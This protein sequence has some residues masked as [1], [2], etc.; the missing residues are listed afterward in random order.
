MDLVTNLK[1]LL[2][3]LETK[4]RELQ[5]TKWLKKQ[6]ALSYTHPIPR[7]AFIA[8]EPETWDK[9]EPVFE[10]FSKREDCEL[11]LYVCPSY[12]S[13]LNVPE[14]YG[15]EW[16]YFFRKYPSF[17]KSIYKEDGSLIDL[18]SEEL[19]YIFYGDPYMGHFPHLYR[20][21][22][23]VQSNAK[24]CYIPYG[25]YGAKFGYDLMANNTDFFKNMYFTF[26][27]CNDVAEIL[28]GLLKDVSHP[29]YRHIMQLGY[30]TLEKF[31]KDK[32]YHTCNYHEVLW[33]P[34]WSYS[35][36]GGGSH[37]LEYK[38]QILGI[39][40]KYNNFHL[41]LRP[42][43]MLFAHIVQSGKMT[44]KEA[45]DYKQRINDAGA[46]LDQHGDV[47]ATIKNT[48]IFVTDYSSLIINFF[49]TGKPIIYCPLDDGYGK[50]Y[51]KMLEGIYIANNYDEVDHYLEML[52][53]GNDPLKN[54]RE[55]ILK[56]PEFSVYRDS[57]ENIVSC[58]LDD[59]NAHVKH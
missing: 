21:Y 14:E 26:A 10:A 16:D 8:G 4:R 49:M 32:S 58:I 7:I 18:N 42:H 25:F 11:F 38:D 57:T 40:E 54:K 1:E 15:Y 43:P 27:D 30:P 34:R 29:E 31:L 55:E 53:K 39:P 50:T 46:A 52:H 47:N 35:N 41:T 48:D 9:S 19:D 20:C 51:T 5:A 24:L 2:R 37:F 23:L 17:C 44:Q 45:D 59:F 56:S 3:P 28:K 22:H 6:H 33:T 13:V 12:D 36:L